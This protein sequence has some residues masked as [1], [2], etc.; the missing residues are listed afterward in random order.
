MPVPRLTSCRHALLALLLVVTACSDPVSVQR[1]D[2]RT[3]YD[4]INRT[5]LSGNTLSDATR[6]VL[7]RN[8]L[9]DAF[10]SYPDA[11]IDALRGQAIARGMP[12]D[13]L[14]ALAEL[15][16]FRGRQTA[17]KPHL[18]AAALYAYAVLFPGDNVADRPGPY[19]SQF[20]QAANFYN[21][22]LTQVISSPDGTSAP[23]RSGRFEL[24]F[25]AIDV[26]VDAGGDQVN[27]RKFVSFVPTMNL[28][29]YGFQNDYHTDGI[30]VPLAAGLAPPADTAQT[31]PTGLQIPAQVRVPTSAVLELP[32]PRRQ[33]AGASLRGTLSVHSI[34]DSLT[35][36]IAGQQ[37]PLEYDQTA[38]RA[39]FITEGR[40][41]TRELSGL[42]AGNLVDQGR[43]TTLYA[44]EPHRR[45]RIPVILV[46]GTA[47]SPFRWAD[48]VN[49]L[50]EDPRIRERYE[51]WLYSYPTGNPIP[52]SALLLRQSLEQTV[53]SLGGVQADPALGRMV[54]IGHSQGGLLTK[55][56]TIETG[57]RLWNM[58]SQRPLDEMKLSPES[59]DLLKA[60]LFLH[61]V[62]TIETVIFIA[63]PHRGSYL[64]GF[65]VAQQITRFITLPLRISAAAAEIL[66]TNKESLRLDPGKTSFNAIYGMSP[67]NPVIQEISRIPVAPPIHAHSIIPELGDGPLDTRNDGVVEYS[68]AHLDGVESELVVN[69]GH[70]T[71]ANPI[72]IGEVRRILLEQLARPPAAAPPGAT[73]A[74][75]H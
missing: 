68:S 7:R 28:E 55:M 11:V 31:A 3:A 22:A 30:G 56:L 65:S 46:H 67:N 19:T 25:G 42:F 48:M 69:S 36:T 39:L 54:V 34:Y 21:L 10:A 14:F 18:L 5:A 74:L 27:G 70:S 73:V 63:T 40:G 26:T 47:S 44:L 20:R 12:W 71:Q 8:A 72:T 58:V 66:T 24:P 17:S 50:L 51:F 2:L 23:L 29:V 37:V 43:G 35:V 4:T 62:P 53:A 61:P 75:A 57:D 59:R 52:Y 49:D 15:N 32:D 41:W 16:Y 38:V 6:I 60:G 33:L 13:D 45:G 9:L 1:V 64:A